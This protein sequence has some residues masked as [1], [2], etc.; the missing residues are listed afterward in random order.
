[1]T[2]EHVFWTAVAIGLVYGVCS[3]KYTITGR[4]EWSHSV[5]RVAGAY[6]LLRGWRR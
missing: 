3:K 4:N 5:L 6:R 1:M 2:F